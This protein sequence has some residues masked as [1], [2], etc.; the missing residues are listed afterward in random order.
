MI[1]VNGTPQ[2]LVADL[3]V[4]GPGVHAN[5]DER[6]FST[7]A[8]IQTLLV[9]VAM[10]PFAKIRTNQFG[11]LRSSLSRLAGVITRVV[12]TPLTTVSA[13]VLVILRGIALPPFRILL[14]G[15]PRARRSHLSLPR[16]AASRISAVAVP[17][18]LGVSLPLLFGGEPQTLHVSS[19]TV[20]GKLV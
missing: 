11:M 10:I 15:I 3:T 14:I 9:W 18:P 8:F 13:V 4:R 7:A 16:S 1:L 6:S 17:F 20:R 19:L 5:V 12:D 2:G